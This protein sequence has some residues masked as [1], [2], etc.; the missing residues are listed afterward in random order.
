[1]NYSNNLKCDCEYD[2]LR[3][4]LIGF[5]S[6]II[7]YISMFVIFWKIDKIEKRLPYV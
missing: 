3:N 1:M 6:L 4:S 2:L 5:I 7:L